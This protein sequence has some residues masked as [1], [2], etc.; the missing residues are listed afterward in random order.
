VIKWADADYDARLITILSFVC[1]GPIGL[2]AASVLD[3]MLDVKIAKQLSQQPLGVPAVPLLIPP[4]IELTGNA[5]RQ[6]QETDAQ[7]H[8]E[9]WMRFAY[10]TFNITPMG[11][12]LRAL[13][14]VDFQ[15]GTVVHA[16][17][18]RCHTTTLEAHQPGCEFGDKIQNKDLQTFFTVDE[19]LAAGFDGC[20]SCLPAA[21]GKGP[22]RVRVTYRNNSK[23]DY[24][25]D[26][27]VTGKRL[28]GPAS[29]HLQAIEAKDMAS[30][31]HGRESHVLLKPLANGKWEFTIQSGDWST[32]VVRTLANKGQWVT[33]K[34]ERN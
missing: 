34:V 12:V 15:P 5:A 9:I 1:L 29:K 19:A 13:I 17:Y 23:A 25:K 4:D 14:K 28:S 10:S 7:K 31:D 8:D 27:H 26:V 22:L 16:P 30:L 24:F 2:L 20:L 3:H 33:L 21:N 6:D 11:L 18:I 32:S